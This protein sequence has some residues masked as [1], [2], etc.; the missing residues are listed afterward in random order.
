MPVEIFE[1]SAWQMSLGER[2]AITGL[3]A[4]LK[5]ALAIEIGSMEGASL[6]QLAAHAAEVHSFDLAPP[7][8]EQPQNVVLHT[9]DSHELL[10]PF[11]AELAGEGRNVD[12]AVVDGDHTAEGVRRD[13]EDLLDSTAVAQTVILIHD[14]ANEQVRS[15]LD[16]VHF[17]AWPKV[18]HVELDWVPGQL[19]AEPALRNELWYGLGLV[20]VDSARLAYNRSVYERRYHPAGPLLAEIRALMR[21]RERVPPGVEPPEVEAAEL[22]KRVAELQSELGAARMLKAELEPLREREERA[23]RAIQNIT[24]SASWRLTRPLRSAKR[25]LA[26]FKR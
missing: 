15:G 11:L 8:L 6:R 5:P 14:T 2:A 7:T 10:P 13:V 4:E 24:S 12:L 20:L 22:R 18:T 21:A 25:G 19:F 23:Q 1:D 26:P 17:P 9:G 3:L 16:A